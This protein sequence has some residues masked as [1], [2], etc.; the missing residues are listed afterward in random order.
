VESYVYVLVSGRLDPGGRCGRWS[1]LLLSHGC[2]ELSQHIWRGYLLQ[3]F[4]ERSY[5]ARFWTRSSSVHFR[6]SW[7]RR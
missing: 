4:E 5:W 3:K 1:R 6:C 2:L 7:L